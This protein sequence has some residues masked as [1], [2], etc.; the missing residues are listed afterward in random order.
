MLR[1]PVPVLSSVLFLGRAAASVLLDS[2]DQ[3]SHLR[4]LNCLVLTSSMPAKVPRKQTDAAGA[5]DRLCDHATC[6]GAA[7]EAGTSREREMHM[8]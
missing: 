2:L 7:G 8:S 5:K 4:R 1:L 6:A 3:P